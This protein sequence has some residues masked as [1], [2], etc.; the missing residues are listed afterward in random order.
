LAAQAVQR[1]FVASFGSDANTATTCGFANPCRSF[2]AAQ[3]VADAGGEIVA[4]C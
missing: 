3:T 2:T 1:S 4:L